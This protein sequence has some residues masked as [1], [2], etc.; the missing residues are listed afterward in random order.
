[1]ILS[2]GIAPVVDLRAA[3]SPVGL[4]V[5]GSSSAD[6]ASLWLEA[7]TG[8]LLAKLRDGAEAVSAR[9][10][11]EVATRGGAACLGR[12]GELGQLAP[13][14]TGDLVV[15]TLDGPAFAGAIADP[16][17]AWLRCG[18]VAP[19]HTIVAGQP[20]VTDG[21]IVRPGLEDMLRRHRAISARIQGL[22]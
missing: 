11:L 10:M 3:G 6:A 2:S 4:G 8:M 12:A 19:R 5:D 1:M 20:V 16:V 15:W 13:G 7:R 9:T 14:A 21:A 17:E 18:P 22:G